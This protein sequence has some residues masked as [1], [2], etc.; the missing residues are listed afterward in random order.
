MT[1]L[2]LDVSDDLLEQVTASAERLWPGQ[3]MK[4]VFRLVRDA[5]RRYVKYCN[6]DTRNGNRG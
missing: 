5:I 6:G 2:T 4:G 1:K 3:E